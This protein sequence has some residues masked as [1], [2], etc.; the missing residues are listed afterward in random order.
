M[1]R[2]FADASALKSN[3]FIHV[4]SDIGIHALGDC[5]LGFDQR[6]VYHKLCRTLR[7]LTA[8]RLS[9]YG[10]FCLEQELVEVLSE[11]E[12]YFPFYAATINM[13][14]LLHLTEQI[15]RSGPV[16]FTWM[17][18]VEREMGRLLDCLH[19]LKCAEESVVRNYLI[20]ELIQQHRV[21]NPNFVSAVSRRDLDDLYTDDGM[22][23]L[24]LREERVCELQGASK[25]R[26]LSADERNE[27]LLLWRIRDPEINAVFERF[28]AN[29]EGCDSAMEHKMRLGP[30]QLGKVFPRAR[31]NATYLRSVRQD[32]RRVN[33]NCCVKVHDPRHG[34]CYAIIDHF[35]AHRA[36][37]HDDAPS[38]V[39]I[40]V[41]SWCRILPKDPETGLMLCEQLLQPPLDPLHPGAHLLSS[42][43]CALDDCCPFPITMCVQSETAH[44]VTYFV[45][46]FSP[47][48]R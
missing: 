5:S 26:V 28:E 10:L 27:L 44:V 47:D 12:R 36:F 30:C 23:P 1:K 17:F 48:D 3:D 20:M 7:A 46:E 19:S 15:E 6:R 31:H 41:A 37:P 4:L 34:W 2:P 14:L 9:I 25:Q 11:W 18:G 42:S 33:T 32:N 8:T 24:Y 35:L 13:H 21:H 40:K 43:F 16:P 39:F 38:S 45:F 22:N 29:V